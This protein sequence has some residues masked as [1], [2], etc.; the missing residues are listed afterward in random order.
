MATLNFNNEPRG[1][2]E[3]EAL[4]IGGKPVESGPPTTGESL[5]YNATSGQ[6]EFGSTIAGI[7]VQSGTPTNGQVLVYNMANNQWEFGSN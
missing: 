6:W 2:R 4:Y 1:I 3:G 7:P 5:S